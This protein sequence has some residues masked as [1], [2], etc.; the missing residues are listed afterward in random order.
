MKRLTTLFSLTLFL[1]A[2]GGGGDDAEPAEETPAPA[3]AP[4]APAGPTMPTGALTMPEWMTFDEAS[5][6]VTMTITA[7]ATNRANYWNYNGYIN[8]E[9]AIN[10]PEGATVTIEFVNQDPAMAHSI[11]VSSE[12]TNFAMPPQPVPVFEG[13]ITSNPQSMIEGG[14]PG[15]TETITF[16]ADAAGDYTLVCYVPGHTAV[17]MWVY[18]RVT[19]DGSV[20]VQGI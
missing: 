10:V 9:I 16:V 11:G 18:F 15:E 4:A 1:A 3:P 12:L 14:M 6:A 2:C 13:A 7:G 20:G 5:N 19:A 8:G 17:G